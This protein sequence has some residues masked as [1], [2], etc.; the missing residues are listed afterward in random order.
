[1]RPELLKTLRQECDT[2]HQA[3]HKHS[4][5]APLSSPSITLDEYKKIISAFF[6]SYKSSEGRLEI[7]APESLPNA[8]VLEW[9]A[10]D[11]ACHGINKVEINVEFPPIDN[12]SK[13]AGYL[14]TKQ[15]STLGGQVISKHLQKYLNLEPGK[16]NFFFSGYGTETGNNWKLFLNYFNGDLQLNEEEVI[17]TA[18]A[19]FENI[20][21]ACDI[22]VEWRNV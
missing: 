19:G 11:I 15:G 18:K 21:N 9:L 17:K 5:L 12:L 2:L 3:L 1:M 10:A 16:E 14:Y 22:M 8:P 4:L 6:L 20:R 7:K 13:L